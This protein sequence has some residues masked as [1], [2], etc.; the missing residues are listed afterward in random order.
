M[1]NI[2]DDIATILETELI[3]L[4][5]FIVPIIFPNAISMHIGK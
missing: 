5:V 3:L 1:C 2:W 4:N